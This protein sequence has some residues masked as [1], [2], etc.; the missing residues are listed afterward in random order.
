MNNQITH[1]DQIIDAKEEIFVT[2]SHHTSNI[3]QPIINSGFSSTTEK[4]L[5]EAVTDN[6]TLSIQLN[7]TITFKC[8]I[9]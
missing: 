6:L 7:F 5:K 9:Y 3:Y 2:T 1:L 8:T 4:C